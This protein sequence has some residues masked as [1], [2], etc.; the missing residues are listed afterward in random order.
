MGQERV[1]LDSEN[2]EIDDV[3]DPDAGGGVDELPDRVDP[4][5]RRADE[6]E[7]V[8]IGQRRAPRLRVCEVERDVVVDAR[9]F[10][11][12]RLDVPGGDANTVVAPGERF[13]HGRADGAR[14]AGYEDHPK[15]RR[16]RST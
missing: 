12:R 1:L 10:V 2:R 9:Q 13:D 8:D 3:L 7:S 14:C 11:P 15:P 5:H 6:E 16:R 4:D